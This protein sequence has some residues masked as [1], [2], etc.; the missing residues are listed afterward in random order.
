MRL[1]VLS[2]LSYYLDIITEYFIEFLT[3]VYCRLYL[4]S[5]LQYLML[6]VCEFDRF[7]LVYFSMIFN[8]I[9]IHKSCVLPTPC[10]ASKLI[11]EIERDRREQAGV[12]MIRINQG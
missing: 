8:P 5:R 12:I 4:I 6:C 7:S 2:L 10:G 3:V 9:C 1:T 11:K